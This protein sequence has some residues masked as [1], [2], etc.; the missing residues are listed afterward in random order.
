MPVR[1]EPRIAYAFVRNLS[2]KLI[3]AGSS[4]AKRNRANYRL[5]RLRYAGDVRQADATHFLR[6]RTRHLANYCEEAQSRSIGALP[7]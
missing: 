3:E 1:P 6:H 2:L 7:S 5:D 4:K